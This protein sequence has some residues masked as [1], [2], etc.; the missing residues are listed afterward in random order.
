[1]RPSGGASPEP[2]GSVDTAEKGDPSAAL[3]LSFDIASDGPAAAKPVIIRARA[4]R[5]LWMCAAALLPACIGLTIGL[6]LGWTVLARTPRADDHVPR[7]LTKLAFGSCAKAELPQPFWHSIV[8]SKPDVFV[9]AGDIVYGDCLHDE[10][11]CAPLDHAWATLGRHPDFA[12][13]RAA[14]LQILGMLDDHDN[15]EN[16]AS[17]HNAYR[18][19]AKRSFLDFFEVPQDDVWRTRPGL[20]RSRVYAGR[21]P[22]GSRRVVQL[23]LLDV[24]SFREP[25]WQLAK[26]RAPGHER[27]DADLTAAGLSASILGD[28]QWAWLEEQLSVKADLRLVVST[29]QVLPLGHGYE[30]WGLFP[31]ELAR[32][33]AAVRTAAPAPSGGRS[34]VLLLSGD[35]H[36]GGLY[37]HVPIVPLP[38]SPLYNNATKQLEGALR[39]PGEEGAPASAH[40]ASEGAA[41]SPDERVRHPALYELTSSSLTHTHECSADEPCSPESG[42]MLGN[43]SLV[44]ENNWGEVEVDWSRRTIRLVL[45][46]A[47]APRAGSGRRIGE[48]LLQHV[49]SFDELGMR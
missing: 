8:E 33:L 29:I 36:L 30:R 12:V 38:P 6:G 20:Y 48:P 4:M 26:E 44:H 5:V 10:Q 39:R 13:A 21:A 32:L 23:L 47:S 11:G 49:V 16:D 15:G 14:P 19:Y 1:M 7:V 40:D 42:P 28:D 9:F 3:A 27:Y 41:A 45:K 25:E 46:Y 37:E 34:G 31:H 35:R 24:R 18:E 22:D 17:G 43:R 2:P